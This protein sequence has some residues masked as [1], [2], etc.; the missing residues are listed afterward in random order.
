MPSADVQSLT[1]VGDLFRWNIAAPVGTSVVVTYSFPAAAGSY[2]TTPR[3]GFAQL[4]A[5]QQSYVRQALATWAAVAGITFVEVPSSVGGQIRFA[6]YDMSGVLNSAGQQAS[7]FSYYPTST[8]TFVNGVPQTT[9]AFNN[10]GGDVFLNS[11][12]YLNNDGQFAP[13]QRGYSI[14]LH[15]IGHALGFKHPFEGTP[16]I[17]PSHD[18]GAYTV[19]SY[20]RPDST[21]Q[22]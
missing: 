6:M 18:N 20:N 12:F 17:D 2:D 9:P 11:N 22:L 15:E 16:V 1:G 13:G 21:T 19:L 7:G 14:V 8:T 10:I 3:P 4:S 5:V